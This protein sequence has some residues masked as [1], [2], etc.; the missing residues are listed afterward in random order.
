MQKILI[1]LGIAAVVTSPAI[2]QI[3][4]AARAQQLQKLEEDLNSSDP[5]LRLAT[6]EVAMESG[7]LAMK[8]KALDLALSSSDKT[9]RFTAMRYF[10]CENK[11]I[12]LRFSPQQ[13]RVS[14]FESLDSGQRSI[15]IRN[16]SPNLGQFQTVVGDRNGQIVTMPGSF[17]SGSISFKFSLLEGSSTS[18]CNASLTINKERNFEGLMACNVAKWAYGPVAA[19]IIN[20]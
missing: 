10:F 6:L 15:E 18:T 8:R 1:F 13:K 5:N 11:L 12:S 17:S 7:S 3:S 2:A 16:C 20:E 9:L 19:V 4:A 14:L